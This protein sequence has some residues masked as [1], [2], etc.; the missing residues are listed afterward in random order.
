[1]D[2]GDCFFSQLIDGVLFCNHYGVDVNLKYTKY[3][4]ENYECLDY[5][6]S[7]N[8]KNILNYYNSF[9]KENFT[10]IGNLDDVYDDFLMENKDLL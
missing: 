3:L 10:E 4:K 1:M 7:E 9:L 5:V 6:N 8:V 2:C